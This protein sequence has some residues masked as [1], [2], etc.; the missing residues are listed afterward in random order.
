[1]CL[2]KIVIIGKGE[3]VPI[4]RRP[5]FNV[6]AAKS[7]RREMGRSQKATARQKDSDLATHRDVKSETAPSKTS[8]D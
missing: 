1:M 3:S 7:D 8:D 4:C 2:S 6:A 5:V